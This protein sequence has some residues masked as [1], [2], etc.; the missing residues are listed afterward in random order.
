MSKAPSHEKLSMDRINA[1]LKKRGLSVK[2]RKQLA[3]TATAGHEPQL[4]SLLAWASEQGIEV[5]GHA[6]KG[7]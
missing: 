6:A 5:V 2:T 4:Q 1:E 3:K 7:L